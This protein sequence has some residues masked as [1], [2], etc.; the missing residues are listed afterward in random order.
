MIGRT[1]HMIP[2]TKMNTHIITLWIWME[3]RWWNRMR[4]IL[5][6]SV[7]RKNTAWKSKVLFAQITMTMDLM[8]LNISM[9]ILITKINQDLNWQIQIKMIYLMKLK[10]M[11]TLTIPKTN[12]KT[13]GSHPIS[14]IAIRIQ[15]IKATWKHWIKTT[16]IRWQMRI[17]FRK[18][19]RMLSSSW[20]LVWPIC[21]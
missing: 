3:I 7:I 15:Q 12:K 16:W 11:L 14:L 4:M 9:K 2:M 19:R 17:S 10:N 5:R 6:C 21:L 20:R 13:T 18:W 8:T 1:T